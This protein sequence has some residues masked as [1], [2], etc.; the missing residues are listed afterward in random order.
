MTAPAEYDVAMSDLVVRVAQVAK[1]ELPPELSASV[2]RIQYDAIEKIRLQEKVEAARKFEEGLALKALDLTKKIILD[3]QAKLEFPYSCEEC[4]DYQASRD[5]HLL[6]PVYAN[7]K[8]LGYVVDTA[9]AGAHFCPSFSLVI[10]L[11]N[12]ANM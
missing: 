1:Y 11:P 3:M 10:N 2:L 5:G 12:K 8:K 6:K 9:H 4:W 7:L